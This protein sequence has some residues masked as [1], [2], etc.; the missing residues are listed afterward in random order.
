MQI[1]NEGENSFDE[2]DDNSMEDSTIITSLSQMNQAEEQ[3]K[4]C[5]RLER[6]NMAAF[7]GWKCISCFIHTLQLVVKSFETNPSFQ[8]SLQKAKRLVKAFNKSC[9]VTERLTERAGK[10]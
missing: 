9:N 4:E 5:D 1:K 10:K 3:I 7:T 6:E 2:D 8:S